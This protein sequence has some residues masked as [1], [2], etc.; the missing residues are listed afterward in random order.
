MDLLCLFRLVRRNISLNFRH[1]AM[2]IFILFSDIS[3]CALCFF[4]LR[5]LRAPVYPSA[6]RIFVGFL[7]LISLFICVFS[8]L[9]HT[10]GNL[11]V[12]HD[13]INSY[14]SYGLG[15]FSVLAGLAAENIFVL[16][17]AACLLLPGYAV[18]RRFAGVSAG[19]LLLKYILLCYGICAFFIIGC[20][21]REIF[22]TSA[23]RV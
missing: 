15:R 20:V 11:I 23:T 14:F 7:C 12:R 6:A 9:C 21:C 17:C 19:A 4:A 3:L 18:F 22:K 5:V 16:F 8:T 13:E 1:Y 2:L 10:L